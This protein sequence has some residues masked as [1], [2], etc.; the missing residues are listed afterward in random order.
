MLF[1]YQ[2]ELVDRFPERHALIFDTGLGKTITSLALAK[3]AGKPFLVV[4][5]K[6]IKENWKRASA[7]IELN[8]RVMT[9]EEFKRDWGIIA[10]YET[11]I[12]DECH[13][14]LGMSSG[15]MRSMQKYFR[16][17]NPQ[18]RWFLTATPYRSSPWDI[19]KLAEL[20]GYPLPYQEFNRKFFYKIPMGFRMIPVVKKGIEKDIASIVKN[21]GTIIKRDEVTDVPEQ[22]FSI[23]YFELSMEQKK[24]INELDEFMPIVRFTK[25]HQI[26]GGGLKGD[27]YSPTKTFHSFKI[28]RIKDIVSENKRTIVVC[29]YTHESQMIKEK[30]IDCGKGVH[31]ITGQQSGE[32]R[33]DT[34]EYLKGQEEYVLIVN[35]SCSEGW[36][37][38]KCPLMVFYSMNFSLIAYIQMIGRIQRINNIKKNN[39]IF[40]LT[41]GEIDESIYKIVVE[42]KMAFQIELY[43]KN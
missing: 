18:F 2:Q 32:E 35:S 10:R 37:L 12:V 21:L 40:L 28:D 6:S 5:P 24:A 30:L 38:P 41:S 42:K 26:C 29:N 43:Q 19:Y 31:L 4:C 39:Y 1:K 16:K 17:W 9:K 8:K 23:E 33:D 20:L 14:F 22:I 13:H 25:E 3:K 27:E 34:L 15:I 11:I 7:G 36:E